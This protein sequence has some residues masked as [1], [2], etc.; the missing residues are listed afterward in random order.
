MVV[1]STNW[2]MGRWREGTVAAHTAMTPRGSLQNSNNVGTKPNE[3]RDAHRHKTV[4][5]NSKHP[6]QHATH[7]SS[8][9]GRRVGTWVFGC[10]GQR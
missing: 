5:D 1:T 2:V 6:D 8:I 3:W 9:V 7:R 4:A 10:V